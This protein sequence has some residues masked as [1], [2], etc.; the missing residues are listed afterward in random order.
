MMQRTKINFP[1]AIVK[2]FLKKGIGFFFGTNHISKNGL[3][4][5][6]RFENL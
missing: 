6:L 1:E 3:S 2:P 4:V 5:A